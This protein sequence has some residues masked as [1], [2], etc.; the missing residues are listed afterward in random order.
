MRSPVHRRRFE[1][2]QHPAVLPG[3]RHCCYYY[4]WKFKNK[5]SHRHGTLPATCDS[6][7]E[8]GCAEHGS[9][10]QPLH[11]LPGPPARPAGPWAQGLLAAA[12]GVARP[13]AAPGP[14][15]VQQQQVMA[16][17]L[18]WAGRVE[19]FTSMNS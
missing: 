8:A 3:V 4:K 12:G 14:R 1:W 19:S 6:R 17:P 11:L 10:A 15:T 5:I 2:C 7:A 16:E 18:T 13:P 9:H